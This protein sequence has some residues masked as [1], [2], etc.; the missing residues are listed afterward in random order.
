MTETNAAANPAALD[1]LDEIRGILGARGVITDAETMEPWLI[2][3]RGRYRG[4]ALALVQPEDARQLAALVR[5]CAKEGIPLVPQGGNSGMVGGAIPDESGKAL[6]LSLRRMNDLCIDAAAGVARCGAGVILQTLHEAAEAR[7]LRFPLSLGGKGSATVGGLISTNAG[8][9]QVLRHG[10]MR[11]LVEGLEVVLADGA[12]L[13]LTSALK[14]DNRGF[15]LKQ[16]W[17][18]SEGTLGIVT[19]AV[20]R[21]VPAVGERRVVWAGIASIGDARR[22]LQH[23]QQAL[24]QALEGFEVI[25]R[26]CLDHVLAYMPKAQAP[27][28]TS[29]GWNALIEF[30]ADGE[31]ASLLGDAVESAMAKALDTGLIEDAV[32]AANEGQA[33]AF[34][35]LREN[36]PSAERQRGPAKQHDISVPVDVMPEVIELAEREIPDLFPGVEVVGF[37]HLGD[38]NIHLHAVAPPGVDAEEWDKTIGGEVSAHVYRMVTQHG[39]SISAE[40]G[41]GQDKLELLRETRDPVA[42]DVMRKVKRAL[43]PE[44]LLNPGKLV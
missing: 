31:S 39:G 34:W 43:D 6:L 44:G 17:I 2:D 7:S 25:P 4:R 41:I 20:L 24:P 35:E 14:K 5:L 32:I 38:G 36:V 8:G 23:C 28:Q 29:H 33:N 3:W 9:T 13:D 37:G 27:L 16:L 22:L 1:L 40:H 18:G 26:P 42:L 12:I 10:T 30:V 11:S 19:R 15:D 21:L